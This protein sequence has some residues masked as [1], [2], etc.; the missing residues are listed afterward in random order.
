MSNSTKENKHLWRSDITGL[1]AL[2]VVPVLLFHAFPN[3]LPGGF[4]G[5]DIFFVISGYLISGII[6]R[7]IKDKG[8]VNFINFYQ[9]RIKRILPNV[10]CV[11][12]F[13]LILGYFFLLPSE[14]KELAKH[15]S[16]SSVFIQNFQLLNEV[17][18]FMEDS[19]RKP[20]LHLWSL[21]IEEQFYILFP[22]LCSLIFLIFK[23]SKSI[24]FFTLSL[25][26]TSFSACLFLKYP[27]FNFYFPVTRFWEIGAGVILAFI[28][29]F[30]LLN[31]G[32]LN[33]TLR[34]ILSVVG[35]FL[36]LF[37]IFIWSSDHSHPGLLTTLP[38][39]GTTFLLAGS[40]TGLVNR[41]LLSLKPLV[42]IGLISYSLYLW[43]WPII[44][45][46][47]ICIPKP[48]TYLMLLA[49]SI[50]FVLAVCAF[51]FIENPFR[52]SRK[53]FGINTAVILIV[54][55]AC[56]FVLG[57]IVD[58]KN[59]IQPRNSFQMS[60]EIRKVREI[61]EWD[62]VS[63]AKTI[64]YEGVDIALANPFDKSFPSILFI[65]DSHMAQYFMR[66][67][68]LSKKEGIQAGF[69][70]RPATGDF[71]LSGMNYP[72]EARAI[73]SLIQDKRIK[74]I[75]LGAAWAY[76]F[77]S[78]ASVETLDKFF[79]ITS[80]RKDLKVFVLLD[81]PWTPEN[82]GKQGDYDPLNHVTRFNMKSN[83]LVPYPK[84]D[85]W[86]KGNE[87]ISK[88]VRDKAKIIDVSSYICPSGKCDLL[89]WYKDDDHL[90]P[91][92]LEMDAVWL[93]EIFE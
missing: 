39:F 90:Q 1:R 75:V 76:S 80:N 79:K 27:S 2:A 50:S 42:F 54:C 91:A 7:E 63:K 87:K 73:F 31:L 55:L 86:E 83:F 58:K 4:F 26:A 13:V 74:K 3:L 67:A 47:Q 23:T 37:P 60:E 25:I 8:G 69:I 89:K 56:S 81:Y 49:L 6:F 59:F 11:F 34:N 72:A 22:L 14:Y 70:T 64:H 61:S 17:G 82:N 16:S 71:I 53:I 43:H 19:Q 32:Q 10:L 57:K 93:N 33:Q 35:L 92:R 12:C 15:L 48:S 9:K 41:S 78:S 38:I 30:Y 44:S 68:L 40:S 65:G 45:F 46:L 29:C 5:V 24:L 85:L 52:R 18:Y 88:I 28:E 21:S 84:E 36:I 77:R 20:L 62:G 66:V 51:Y